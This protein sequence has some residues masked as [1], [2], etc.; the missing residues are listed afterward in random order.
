MRRD[1]TPSYIRLGILTV[2]TTISWVFFGVYRTLTSKPTPTLS[3]EI[4]A[5]FD[6]TLDTVKIDAMQGK[7]FF[8]EGETSILTPTPTP[9]A[10]PTASPTAS[11]TPTGTPEEVTP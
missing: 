2:I 5:P 7:T 4:L 11:P 1:K 6:P 3:A 8:G 9:S 10:T